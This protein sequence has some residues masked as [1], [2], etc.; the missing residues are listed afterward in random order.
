MSGAAFLEKRIL[1]KMTIKLKFE[2]YKLQKIVISTLINEILV[3]QF[4]TQTHTNGLENI[5]GY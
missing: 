1:A 2:H 4:P 3:L 5:N